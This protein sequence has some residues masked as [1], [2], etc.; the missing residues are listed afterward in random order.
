MQPR[1]A[2]WRALFSD[3]LHLPMDELFDGLDATTR[4]RLNPQLQQVGMT[5]S[6]TVLLVT[7]SIEVT[8]FLSDRIVVM[9]L[10]DGGVSESIVLRPLG[11]HHLRIAALRRVLGEARSSAPDGRNP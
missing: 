10:P 9:T 2:I 8:I 11:L 4:E 5:T 3:R 7:H 6:K 1:V